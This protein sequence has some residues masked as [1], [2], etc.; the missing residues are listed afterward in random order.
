MQLLELARVIQAEREAAITARR[1]WL[2]AI[3][4]P[5]QDREPA[6]RLEDR[7]VPAPR[8]AA[9]RVSPSPIR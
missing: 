2:P 9:A 4:H 3:R 1:R 8:R 7:E 5:L 6:V